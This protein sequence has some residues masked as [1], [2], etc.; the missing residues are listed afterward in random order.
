MKPENQYPKVK[1]LRRGLAAI[2]LGAMIAPAALPAV[3]GNTNFALNQPAVEQQLPQNLPTDAAVSQLRP[4]IQVA[5]LL[6]TSNSMDGLIDQTRNQLWQVVNEFASARQNG[7]TPILEIAL[8]EYGNDNNAHKSGY[9]RMLHAFTRELDQVSEGL[10][11][12]TTSGGNEY[13]GFAISK[14]S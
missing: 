7:V 10:F 9:V 4:R 5:I 13:C 8:F 2:A 3:A 1:I 12:L 6:D 11:S 14:K